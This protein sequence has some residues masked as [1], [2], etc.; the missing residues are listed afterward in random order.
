MH[1]YIVSAY[2]AVRAGLAAL[3]REQPGWLVVGESTP[4][5]LARSADQESPDIDV[6]RTVDILLADLDGITELNTI[7]LWLATL[8]PRAGMVGMSAGIN[9]PQHAGARGRATP[10]GQPLLAAI[11]RLAEDYGIAFGLLLRDAATA[12]IVAAINAVAGGLIVL[13]RRLASNLLAAPERTLAPAT[14][15]LDRDEALTAREFEVLQ[16]MAQGLPNKT[17]AA[18]LHISEHT[19][20]YHVSTIMMKLGAAS[21]TEAVTIAARRGLLIL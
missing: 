21:R 6:N 14:E 10:E 19:A 9:A 15:L 3:M 17:I 7:A 4:D 16:L 13:D 11:A 8:H 18:R 1:I 2:P 20:K 5:A 12:E